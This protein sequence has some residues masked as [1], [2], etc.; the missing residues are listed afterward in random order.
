MSNYLKKWGSI[1]GSAKLKILR[2]GMVLLFLKAG[3]TVLSFS[4]FRR[5]FYRFSRSER[6]N[7]MTAE[8]IEENVWAVNTAANVLPIEL[9]CLPRALAT[10]YLLRHVPALS[11]EIGVEINPAK[12]FEAHAWVEKEGE[13]IIGDW[14]DSVSYQRL[15]VWE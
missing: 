5:L 11:L 9:L 4:T 12:A 8:E 1:S 7:E 3:L 10:K 14:S 6:Y 2:A 15:W 13:I